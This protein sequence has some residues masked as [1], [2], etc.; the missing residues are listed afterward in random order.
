MALVILS[1]DDSSVIRERDLREL[2]ESLGLGDPLPEQY[3]DWLWMNPPGDR[4]TGAW[5]R[6]VAGIIDSV[7][8]TDSRT[9]VF[10]LKQPTP[11]LLEALTNHRIQIAHPKHL[12]QPEIDAGN[13]TVSPADVD[14]V[15]LGPFVF[16]RFN[17]GS[18]WSVTRFDQYWEI[19]D[20]NSLPYLDGI[21]FAIV[22]DHGSVP[23]R[24]PDR[25]PGQHRLRKRLLRASPAAAA[26]HL[27]SG[28]GRGLLRHCQREPAELLDQCR[29]GA[30]G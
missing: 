9:A 4:P 13:V 16:D 24:I 26:N 25:T 23:C 14:Y 1:S 5:A 22:P 17:E 10:R 20:G 7:E 3:G 28:R 8:A 2:R 12:M 30:V 18:V 29:K 19:E 27:R 6:V 11:S 21:D 15:G